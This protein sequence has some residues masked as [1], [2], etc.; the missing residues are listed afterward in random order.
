V[1]LI[2]DRVPNP[3]QHGIPLVEEEIEAEEASLQDGELQRQYQEV[4]YW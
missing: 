2:A 3:N 4:A 1:A